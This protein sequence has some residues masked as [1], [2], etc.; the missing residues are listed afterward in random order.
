[1]NIII[2]T[3][4]TWCTGANQVV[5][6][7]CI[8]HVATCMYLAVDANAVIVVLPQSGLELHRDVEAQPRHQTAPLRGGE[9]G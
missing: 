9:V 7:H 8:V 5:L 2:A 1:M 3:Q 6:Q 4:T